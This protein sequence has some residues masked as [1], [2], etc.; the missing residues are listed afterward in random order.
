MRTV[1]DVLGTA[2]IRNGGAPHLKSSLQHM[3]LSAPL[4]VSRSSYMMWPDEHLGGLVPVTQ[5]V[6]QLSRAL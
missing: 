3:H 2:E 5:I 6:T 4:A 1:D